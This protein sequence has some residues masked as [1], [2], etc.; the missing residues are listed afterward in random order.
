VVIDSFQFQ[1]IR[2]QSGLLTSQ[3]SISTPPSAPIV[4]A[5][6]PAAPQAAQPEEDMEEVLVTSARRFIRQKFESL[7]AWMRTTHGEPFTRWVPTAYGMARDMDGRPIMWEAPIS[8]AELLDLATLPL[9]IVPAATL[10]K[11]GVTVTA[12]GGLVIG[13]GADLAKP[14]ALRAGEYALKWESKLPNF[15]AEW[16]EN[17]GR[18]REVMRQGNPI[19]DASVGNTGGMFLNA[20]RALLTERGWTFHSPSGMWMPPGP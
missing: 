11:M 15:K 20:E 17:A 14:G 10:G 12:R 9:S 1:D 6:A 19:R 5:S 8:N 2:Y 7:G 13:R 3:P 18:L 16:A 4:S